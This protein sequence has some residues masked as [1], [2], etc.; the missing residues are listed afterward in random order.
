MGVTVPDYQ[1]KERLV[2]YLWGGRWKDYEKNAGDSHRVLSGG[3]VQ[4]HSVKVSG[5]PS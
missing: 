4:V 3:T 1:G 5:R 2:L